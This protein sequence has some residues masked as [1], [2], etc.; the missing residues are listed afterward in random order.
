M[1]DARMFELMCRITPAEPVDIDDV[2]YA[3]RPRPERLGHE[4]FVPSEAPAIVPL[5]AEDERVT[6]GV[7]VPAPLPDPADYAMRLAALAAERDVEIVILSATDYCG[8][9][10]FGFRVERVVSAEPQI[11]ETAYADL[12]DFW[13][14]DL[15]L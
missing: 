12:K 1:A 11:P 14:L 9:E 7:R 15:I 4:V 3:L 6:L 10:R 2:V 13:K 5:A 8:L